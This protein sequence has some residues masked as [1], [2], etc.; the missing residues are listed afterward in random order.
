MPAWEREAETVKGEKSLHGYLDLLTWQSRRI[1]LIPE[2]N[3]CRNTVVRRVS[4][5]EGYRLAGKTLHGRETMMAFRRNR[6]S[7]RQRRPV[8]R[9]KVQ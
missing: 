4:I 2:G 1:L 6:K 8:A 3:N 9:D 5:M 7:G